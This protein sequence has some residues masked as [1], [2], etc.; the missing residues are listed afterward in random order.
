MHTGQPNP[1]SI[2]NEYISGKIVL[3]NSNNKYIFPALNVSKNFA[4]I[5]YDAHINTKI[6]YTINHVFRSM[7]V[8]ELNTLHTVCELER[9]QLLTILAMSVQNP[10]LAG[11][12]LTGNRSNF[13]YVEGS[14]AWLYDCPHFLSPLYTADRCFDRIPIHFKDTLMYFAPI[15]RQTYDYAPPITCD[16]NPNNLIELDPDFDYQDFYILGPEPI[17]RKP[18]LLFTPSKIKTTKRSNTL[19]AQDAGIYSNAEL[20]QFWNRILF[21]KNSDTTLQLLG[22]ALSYSFIS[23]NTPDSPHGNPYNTL[24]NGLHDRLINLTPLFTPTWFSDAFIALFGYPCYIL[25]QCGIYFST[26]LF[27]QTMLTLIVNLY[28]TIS[29]KYNLEQNITIINSIA[30]G[31]LNILT[32]DMIHDLKMFVLNHPLKVHIKCQT[33]LTN[34]LDESSYNPNDTTDISSNPTGITSPPPFYTKRPNRISK[35]TRFKF[36]PKR[37][38][39]SNQTPHNDHSKSNTQSSLPHYSPV[40]TNSNDYTLT[41][42]PVD[43]EMDTPVR[44]YSKTN[45]SF[46]PPSFNTDHSDFFTPPT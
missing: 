7:T 44:V 17:K 6:D 22:K 42:S 32:A 27:L 19:K 29:I 8:Q 38:Q 9:N 16:N 10:Q 28:K 39:Y 13:L 40:T 31:F 3:N 23:S 21:S 37:K 30:H 2:I 43:C 34:P 25:T 26:Y 5:D 14:T 36:L 35:M 15:T 33:L 45:Y 46:P 20:N 12:F 1:T 4:T 41:T 24:R 11:F 18:P